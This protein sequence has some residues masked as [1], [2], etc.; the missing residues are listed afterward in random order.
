MSEKQKVFISGP[1]TGV[2]DYKEYFDDAAYLIERAGMIPLNPA[3]LPQGMDPGDYMR[4]TLAMIDAADILM[5]L[6][7]WEKSNGAQLENGY[8]EYQGKP[9]LDWP[10]FRDKYLH[11]PKPEPPATRSKRRVERLFGTRESWGGSSAPAPAPASPST[12]EERRPFNPADGHK[13]F[14]LVRCPDCGEVRGFCAK[15]PTTSSTCRNCGTEIPLGDLIPAFIGC[16]KCG[17]RYKYRTNIVDQEP[18]TFNCLN[19]DAPVDL[20][21]NTRGTAVVTIGDN[22]AGG[23]Y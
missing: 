20:Q 23:G 18:F 12:P 17:A 8:A 11:A 10:H 21:L 1:I 3:V 19:C 6:N 5:M 7:D 4:I 13:G 22:S 2:P 14:L 9:C 16:K 15:Q